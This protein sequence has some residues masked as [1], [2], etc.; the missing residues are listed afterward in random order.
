MKTLFI[1]KAIYHS[2]A[3]NIVILFTFVRRMKGILEEE[4]KRK[5]AALTTDDLSLGSIGVLSFWHD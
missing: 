4:K 5:N 2:C 1:M 3:I